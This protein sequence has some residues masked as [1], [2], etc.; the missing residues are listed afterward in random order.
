MAPAPSRSPSRSRTLPSALAREEP[1]LAEL[2]VLAGR[3]LP[4]PH[5]LEKSHEGGDD[6]D[7]GPAGLDDLGEADLTPGLG[8]QRPDFGHL[9][10][11]GD[12]GQDDLVHHLLATAGEHAAKRIEE[13]EERGGL[14]WQG[15]GGF[16]PLLV[17]LRTNERA[18]L[19]VIAQGERH[20]LELTVLEQAPDQLGARVTL[21]VFLLE[22]ARGE[23]EA[24]LDP[25]QGGR[26]HQEL[27]GH[28]EV[29]KAHRLDGLQVL[30]GDMRDRDV[31][32]INLIALDEMKKQIERTLEGLELE[33][34]DVAVVRTE[35]GDHM[36]AIL[37]VMP[38]PAQ[39]A[40]GPR[41]P[42]PR[43]PP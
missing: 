40:S 16:D 43:S 38:M 34:Q 31:V 42:L 24:G 26:H 21:L 10:F 28:I 13:L 5:Q 39:A 23:Q 7:P 3:D 19:L 18:P 1:D 15:L 20:L 33:A 11:H 2:L 25:H 8:Q 41:R 32:D 4:E 6:L 29:E 35:V 30:A 17:T 9:L 36:A 12:R 27:A 22:R 14:E 37:A